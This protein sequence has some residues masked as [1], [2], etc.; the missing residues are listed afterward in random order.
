M[1]AEKE[2]EGGS[3]SGYL[4]SNCR[5]QDLVSDTKHQTPNTK[6]Q[7]PNTLLTCF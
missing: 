4:K 7:A 2:V 5:Q 1:S 6:H 3:G